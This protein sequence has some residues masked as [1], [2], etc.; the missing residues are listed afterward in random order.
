MA[1]GRSIEHRDSNDDIMQAAV[2]DKVPDTMI[3]A[4]RESN[5]ALWHECIRYIPAKL[6]AGATMLYFFTLLSLPFHST[7]LLR[8][9]QEKFTTSF[10]FYGSPRNMCGT[11][12]GLGLGLARSFAPRCRFKM[13]RVLSNQQLP[14]EVPLLARN[15]EVLVGKRD[16]HFRRPALT[17]C[18]RVHGRWKLQNCRKSRRG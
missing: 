13:R 17:N 1:R 9:P 6:G 2:T 15:A 7:P 8:R 5:A 12:Y 11:Y 10:P 3:E 14:A 16:L 18:Q 4:E